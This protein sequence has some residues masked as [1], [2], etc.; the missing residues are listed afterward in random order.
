MHYYLAMAITGS[1]L[2][3]PLSE[4][5]V[6]V[7]TNRRSGF[8]TIS[9]D[10]YEWELTVEEGKV[11]SYWGP[12]LRDNLAHIVVTSGMLSEDDLRIAHQY[13]RQN[14]CTL[15]RALL[16]L[17]MLTPAQLDECLEEV[18]TESIFDLFIPLPGEFVYTERTGVGLDLGFDFAPEEKLPLALDVNF[19]LMEGARRQD[20]WS[21]IRERFPRDDL[22]VTLVDD[23]LRPIEELGVRERRVLA[24]LSAGQ[25]ISDICLEM[26]APIPSVLRIIAAFEAEGAVAV[27]AHARDGSPASPRVAQLMA[28]ARVLR[29]AEQHD[30]AIRLIEAAVRMQPGDEVARALLQETIAD[31]I[32][33]LY[34][35]FPPVRVPVLVADEMKVRNL[36]L[37]PGERFLMDRLSAEMDVG[38]LVMISSMSERDTLKTLRKLLHA[39]IVELR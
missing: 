7:Q 32:R 14:G 8:I 2:T 34:R 11:T 6:W 30:E 13:Q 15:K 9:R 25:S 33:A 18:A 21:H 23:K 16:D 29:E 17:R 31:Q 37:R 27:E 35:L 28:Q 24:S 26:H 20:E 12:E 1:L 19:L 5:L 38:A 4:L 39:G 22:V 3:M 36:S 10:S